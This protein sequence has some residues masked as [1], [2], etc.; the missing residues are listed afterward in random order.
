MD[1]LN[2]NNEEDEEAG[3][4][5]FKKFYSK[6]YILLFI[7]L[8]QQLIYCK[9]LEQT[10]NLSDIKRKKLEKRQMFV[11]KNSKN[12]LIAFDKGITLFN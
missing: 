12:N 2:N 4:E 10:Y 7:D 6:Y 3:D 11:R 5:T 1:I 9:I 8:N